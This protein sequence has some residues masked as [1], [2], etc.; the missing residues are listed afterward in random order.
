MLDVYFV[1]A[2]V[3]FG[4]KSIK[5][6]NRARVFV[7]PLIAA[8]LAIVMIIFSRHQAAQHTDEVHRFV[9]RL[10]GDAATG[11]DLRG[12][13]N[14]D[15]PFSEA[16]TL[17]QLRRLCDSHASASRIDVIAVD[18]QSLSVN[19]SATHAVILRQDGADRLGLL[20]N[21]DGTGPILISGYWLPSP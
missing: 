8:L 5:P 3:H 21:Y 14:P 17:E 10:C 16:Q 11:R 2:G 18:P 12:A 13:L 15:D 9:Q 6:P 1:V 7:V 19:A 4:L 20:V